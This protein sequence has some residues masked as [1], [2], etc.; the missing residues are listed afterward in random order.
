VT[1]RKQRWTALW[2]VSTCVLIAGCSDRPLDVAGDAGGDAGDAG[3]EACG[4]PILKAA[5]AE[6]SAATDEQTCVA[7]GGTWSTIGLGNQFMCICQTGEAECPCTQPSD[8]ITLCLA[9]YGPGGISDCAGIAE[10]TCAAGPTSGCWCRL[11][12]GGLVSWVCWD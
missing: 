9:P 12:A 4:D 6:C 10:G 5:Y 3:S 8:C 2:A 7:R 11:E 1:T